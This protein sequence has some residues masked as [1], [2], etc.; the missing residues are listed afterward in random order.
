MSS[1]ERN[2][3]S[4]I[5]EFAVG[6]RAVRAVAGTGVAATT[7]GMAGYVTFNGINTERDVLIVLG[8]GVVG[9]ISG[10]AIGYTLG[11]DSRKKNSSDQPR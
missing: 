1:P 10:L 6:N 5:K 7:L 3:G 11:E 2:L 4:K 9:G 8:S